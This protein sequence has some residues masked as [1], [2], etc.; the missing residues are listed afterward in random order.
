M[1]L[2]GLIASAASILEGLGVFVMIGGV[3]F[4]LV[5][6]LLYWKR[7]KNGAGALR[8]FRQYLGR[9]I[10]LGLEFLVA[11]D[12]IR[13]VGQVPTLRSVIILAIVVMI[14]TTLSFTLQVE[15]EGRW[16]WQQTTTDQT[17]VG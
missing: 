12:I 8:Y 14:R 6:A 10:L 11:S 7:N 17:H 1:G 15:I 9:V 13:T 5:L 3:P 16:P 4:V 2:H